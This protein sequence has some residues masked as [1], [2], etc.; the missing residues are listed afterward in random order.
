MHLGW[1]TNSTANISRLIPIGV[2]GN[3]PQPQENPAY[4]DEPKVSSGSPTYPLDV[5]AAISSDHK[6]MTVSVVN[7]TDSEQKVELNGVALGGPSTLWQL[8]AGSLDAVNRA[9]APQQ[10]QVKEIPIASAPQTLTVAPI[11]VNVY[12]FPVR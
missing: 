6:F 1:S 7:A 10:V 8:T 11:S 4:V 12:R 9:G 3:S 5:F 2:S